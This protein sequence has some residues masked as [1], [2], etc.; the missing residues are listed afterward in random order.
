MQSEQ[1]GPYRVEGLLGRGTRGDRVRATD[2]DQR[3]VVLEVLP[4]ELSAD[5]AYA[6][7]FRRDADLAARLD[8]PHLVPVLRSGELD[9]RLYA[10]RPPLPG[11]ELAAVLAE[12]PL[13]PARA[14]SL[15]GELA[16]GL[17]AAHAAGL[18]HGDLSA[19]A[20][21]LDDDGSVRL[22]G[23]GVP[24]P[25][26]AGPRDDVA[27]LAAL[28]HECLTGS[29]PSPA[30]VQPPSA[31]RPGVPPRLDAVV[32]TGL[33]D[34]PAERYPSAGQLAAAARSA[35]AGSGG[36]SATPGRRG[37]RLLPLAVV[38]V[39]GIAVLAALALVAVLVLGR[40]DDDPAPTAD[41]PTTTGPATTPGA[42]ADPAAEDRLRGAIPI[43]FPSIDCET[44][45]PTDDGAL[46][47]LGCGPSNGQ[48]GPEDSVFYL[49]GD[50]VTAQDVFL[51]DMARNGVA[52]LPAGASCPAVQGHGFYED[53]GR[54][55]RIGC[56][57]D[58]ENNAILSWTQDD[59]AAQGYVI[60]IDGG[61]RGLDVLYAWWSFP[62]NE[63]SD[64]VVR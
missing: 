2:S 3:R 25:V 1:F 45:E 23:L 16:A 39:A 13:D 61:Q 62:E 14:V 34:D 51:A 10:E 27:A 37:R 8:E 6:E 9:G 19:S 15:V 53:D 58:A 28:L 30:D 54:T 55:G 11:R 41:A 47:V 59:I 17:D 35:L 24:S 60:V 43:E 12:G 48:P 49:Y 52:P 56:W 64:F 36:A 4:E 21:L 33:A 5:P 18:V 20:V 46:A 7:R 29:R 57:V 44:G 32:L 22:T 26:P 50:T 42:P 31:V 38:G 63:T 40:T